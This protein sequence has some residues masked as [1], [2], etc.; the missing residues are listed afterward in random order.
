MTPWISVAGF[1]LITVKIVSW[2]NDGNLDLQI[3]QQKFPKYKR[4][5][6]N[7]RTEDQPWQLWTVPGRALDV[8]NPI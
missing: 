3:V 7:L 2:D 6:P 5:D 8:F 4:K 1:P